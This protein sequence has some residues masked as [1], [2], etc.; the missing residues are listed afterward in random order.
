VESTLLLSP[1]FLSAFTLA[2][3]LILGS[4][5]RRLLTS[6]SSAT[7]TNA[8]LWTAKGLQR[9]SSCIS[10]KARTG[11]KVSSPLNSR[12]SGDTPL[13]HVDQAAVMQIAE[14]IHQYLE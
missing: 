2:A 9:L 4:I 5:S 10:D 6:V 8:P 3:L 7:I 13:R 1:V 11:H 12:G 14:M